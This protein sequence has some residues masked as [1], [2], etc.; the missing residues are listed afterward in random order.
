M[1]NRII[2]A[3]LALAAV[4][5]TAAAAPA[6][7]A[8]VF[9]PSRPLVEEGWNHGRGH[10]KHWERGRGHDRDYYRDGYSYGD[11][12]YG[13]RY[14]PRE[15]W[16]GHDGRYYCKRDDGTTGL[17]IGALLGGVVGNEVAGRGDRTLGAVIGAVGG[18]LLGRSIDRS[19]TRCR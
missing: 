2:T 9:D 16:R 10:H 8:Q 15:V 6:S 5:M 11:R 14:R 12:Y 13:D 17:V 1:E 18:G 4:G 7:A 3:A 19:G